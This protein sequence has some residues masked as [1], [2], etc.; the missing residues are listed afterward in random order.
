M[1]DEK[2]R[3][4]GDRKIIFDAERE[5]YIGQLSYVDEKT[6]KRYRPKVYA[7]SEAS[8]R[9]KMKLKEREIAD[10]FRPD[11]GGRYTVEQ[12]LNKWFEGF[13]KN[14]I[15][16]KTQVRQE[17]AIKQITDRIGNI[18]LNK[19]TTEDVQDL[20]TELLTRGRK[21]ANSKDENGK[22][23]VLIPAGLSPASVRHC[24]C[25]LHKALKKAA[26]LQYVKTNVTDAVELPKRS[27]VERQA[28]TLEQ[29]TKFLLVAKKHRLY[30]CFLLA[31]A[32]G[33]RRGELL[34]LSWEDIDLGKRFLRVRRSLLE[35]AS[36]GVFIDDV[37]SKSSRRTVSFPPD[38]ADELKRHKER[39]A[40]E[41]VAAKEKAAEHAKK[42]NVKVDPADYYVDS[43]MIFRQENGERLDPRAFGRTYEL[44]LSEAGLPHFQFHS[45]RHTY[46]TLMLQKGVHL[47][48]VQEALGHSTIQQTADTYSHVMPG[49]MEQAAMCL[50]G[51]FI[52]GKKKKPS[53]RCVKKPNKT[54][55]KMVPNLVP[56]G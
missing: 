47:K 51:L 10:G 30:A 44:L 22:I 28:M 15:R 24:H 53:E 42:F 34:A 20:Y 49:M 21:Q 39:Q 45:L 3:G 5:L 1:P 46:A 31:L 16:V 19:L 37:K 9:A 12:W 43:G 11:K 8:C 32:T 54:K 56:K 4:R 27:K 29:V 14:Q 6:G 26:A 55:K 40:A 48:V 50:Q 23:K 33:L 17:L 7:D 25:V 52:E 13:Q 35:A 41:E 2:R 36:K 38:V 18:K